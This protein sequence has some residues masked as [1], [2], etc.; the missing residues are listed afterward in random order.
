[1][2]VWLDLVTRFSRSCLT[3]LGTLI[4]IAVLVSTLGLAKSASARI[5]TRFDA[6][7]A[8][9]VVVRS[10]DE[11]VGTTEASSRAS[12]PGPI[13]FDAAQRLAVIQGV[14]SS[15][16]YSHLKGVKE[17]RGTPVNDPTAASSRVEVVAASPQLLA[18]VHGTVSGRFFDRFHDDRGEA[19]AVL[20]AEAAKQLNVSDVDRQPAIFLDGRSVVVIGILT[21]LGRK[22]ELLH[23][24]VVP[25]GLARGQYGLLAPEQVLVETRIGAADV[26]GAQVPYALR[27]DQPRSLEVVVPPTPTLTRDQ[28][29]ADTNALFLVLGGISLLI[30]GLG[31]ANVTLVSVLERVPEIGLRRALGARRGHV[32]GHFLMESTALGLLG[33]VAGTAVGVLTTVAVAR[34]RGWPPAMDPW[35][36]VL[37]PFLGA[38]IGLLSGIYPAVRAGRIEPIDAL[39]AA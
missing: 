12:E 13:P 17:V 8:T 4:G 5:T 31:I 6:L 1:M 36:P 16:T 7:A 20:G 37:A 21:S 18:T 9:E 38:M 19:V 11:Q 39:R 27:P 2:D 23:S 15:S 22:P 35:L 10:P 14:A 30:G 25:D 28:V 34:L 32:V 26:V 33:A 24:V 29:S 3:A